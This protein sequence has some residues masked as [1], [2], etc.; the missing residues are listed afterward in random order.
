MP[1]KIYTQSPMEETI[2][3]DTSG[4][5][6]RLKRFMAEND[7]SQSD[8][9]AV[10][11]VKQSTISTQLAKGDMQMNVILG[12]LSHYRQVSPDWLLLGNG[13]MYRP[14]VGSPETEHDTPR[15]GLAAPDVNTPCHNCSLVH[16]LSRHI[17]SLTELLSRTMDNAAKDSD[18]TTPA[19]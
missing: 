4:I 2:T 13:D 8:L 6:R 1:N 16:S 19:E 18:A 5:A 15:Q 9:A 3:T 14:G 17:G 12:T 10:S 11:G 7:I